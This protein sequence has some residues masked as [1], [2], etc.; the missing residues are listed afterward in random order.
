MQI[1][2]ALDAERNQDW[3]DLGDLPG[4]PDPFRPS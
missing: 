1:D 4:L 2:F 3:A